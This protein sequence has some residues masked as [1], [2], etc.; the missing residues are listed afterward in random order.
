MLS[1][2]SQADFEL[3]EVLLGFLPLDASTPHTIERLAKSLQVRMPLCF[4][5]SKLTCGACRNLLS[6]MDSRLVQ[7][8]P[9]KGRTSLVLR[10]RCAQ[11][12]FATAY[13][14]VQRC[15]FPLASLVLHRSLLTQSG[16]R[17]LVRA[18]FTSPACCPLTSLQ[19]TRFNCAFGSR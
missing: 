8:R 5:S 6:T 3:K 19:P 18:G 7:L 14:R 11:T 2:A 9:T 16:C 17:A 1:G 12:F 4:I 15:V 10:V 13:R